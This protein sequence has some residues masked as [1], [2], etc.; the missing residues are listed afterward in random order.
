[1]NVKLAEYTSL[2]SLEAY[3]VASQDEPLCRVWQRHGEERD[4]PQEPHVI[5][6]GEAVIALPALAISLPL[7]VIYRN[8][9]TP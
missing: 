8:I 6:G 2:P 5:K 9:V 1:M 7:S 3:I 4:F